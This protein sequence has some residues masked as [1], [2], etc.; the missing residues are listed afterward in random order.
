MADHAFPEVVFLEFVLKA[1]LDH[2]EA[3]HIDRRVDELGTLLEL[4]VDPEDTG[5]VIG[6]GGQTLNSIRVL[7]RL[8]GAKKGGERINIKLLDHHD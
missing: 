3:I 5:K 6:K 8:L 7:L 1:L 4:T 2:P